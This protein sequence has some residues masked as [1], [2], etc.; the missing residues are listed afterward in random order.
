M[1]KQK[2]YIQGMHCPSC[3][4]LIKEEMQKIPGIISADVSLQ[5]ESVDFEY[6]KERLDVDKLNRRFEKQGYRFFKEPPARHKNKAWCEVFAAVLLVIAVFL[7]ISKLGLASFVNINPSSS[8]PAFFFFGFIAGISSCAALIGGLVLSLSKS[9][10]V[11]SEK[12]KM[13]PHFL[14]N[15]GR[16]VSFSIFGAIL[17]FVGEKFIISPSLTSALVIFISMIMLVL[18]FQMLGIKTFNRFRMA[19]PKNIST[20]AA[21]G[22]GLLKD[23]PFLI[24][25][26]TFLLPCGFT[27]IAEGAAILSG[28]PAGGL[29]I[30]LLFA[31]GTMFPLMA[32]GFSSNKLLNNK[33]SSEKFLKMVGILVIFLVIYNID[34]QFGISQSL[35]RKEA[36]ISGFSRTASDHAFETDPD[37]LAKDERIIKSIY[38]YSSDI[39]PNAFEIKKGQRV[40]FEVDTKENG[41][42]CM[43]TIMI[44]GVWNTPL[45]L[46]AGKTLVMEFTPDKTGTYQITCAMGVPRGTIK[47]VD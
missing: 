22:K 47:V 41:L 5:R 16:L 24:G 38:T 32:I 25:F 14:F 13:K 4:L 39:Q 18:A 12:N 34:F 28:S 26:V 11:H 19:L 45:P 31:L 1:P 6:E 10:N 44:P 36:D 43:S 37:S 21:S 20:Y 7:I 17:G 35:L 23:T 2:Y 46:K 3:E 42:G 27:I 33:S 9:W 8:L 15:L 29:S 40:R 30:M